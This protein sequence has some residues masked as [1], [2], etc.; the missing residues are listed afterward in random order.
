MKALLAIALALGFTIGTAEAGSNSYG[1]G[2]GH[3][4][5]S[6]GHGGGHAFRSHGHGHGYGHGHQQVYAPARHHA[7]TYNHAPAYKPVYAPTYSHAPVYKPV[8]APTYSHAPVYKPAYAPT[9]GHGHGHQQVVVVKRA[10]HPVAGIEPRQEL[11]SAEANVI[12]PP[13]EAPVVE[14]QVPVDPAGVPQK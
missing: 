8:Y 13:V 2:R 11:K 12:T 1:H 5:S 9:Y 7:P 4:V 6:Y 3:H 10:P 14:Q